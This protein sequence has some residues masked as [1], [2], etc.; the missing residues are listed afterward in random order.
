MQKSIDVLIKA[1]KT[2]AS[3][4]SSLENKIT[5]LN[6]ELN[7]KDAKISELEKSI[8]QIEMNFKNLQ[9]NTETNKTTDNTALNLNDQRSYKQQ[10]I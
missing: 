1:S 10:P 4:T 2:Q 3:K 6:C 7:K 9:Y 8:A 5:K